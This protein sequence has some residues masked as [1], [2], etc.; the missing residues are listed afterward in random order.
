MK[1]T[2][3]VRSTLLGGVISLIVTIVTFIGHLL[4][5]LSFI[6][7]DIFDWMARV[8]PGPLIAHVIDAIVATINRF[9]LGPTASTAK[10][11]EQGIAVV[12]F[13]IFGLI[14]GLIIGLTS[15]RK[16]IRS[17]NLGLG[18]GIV[19]WLIAV[20]IDG[21][22][23]FPSD[24]P[25]LSILWLGVVLISAG[26]YLGKWIA[27]I[28]PVE[29]IKLSPFSPERRKFLL[30]TGATGVI[31]LFG[32]AAVVDFLR[33]PSGPLS[34]AGQSS[35]APTPEKLLPP[36]LPSSGP[37]PS[38]SAAVLAKRILAAPGTR[39][40]LTS[41]PDFYRI[42]INTEVPTTDINK[43][44]LD[45]KGLVDNPVSL[46]IDQIRNRPSI[47][48]AITLSCISN[49]VG[50]DLISTGVWT[51]VPLKS[52]L[53]ELGVKQGAK[54]IYMT[55]FDG[56]YETLSLQEAMDERV[57]LVYDMNGEPL[58]ANHGFPLRIYIPNHYGMKQPKWISSLEL[59]DT[60]QSGYWV[61]RGW[62]KQATALTTSVIDT[63][64][65]AQDSQ[66]QTVP[67][68]GIAWAGDRG[69]QKVEVQVDNGSWV[70][71]QL[72][73]PPLSQLTWVQ[74]RYNFPYKVGYH[75]FAVRATD[76]T[77]AVQTQRVTDTFPAGATGY[78][79]V[80]INL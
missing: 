59:T 6:P 52:I 5:G 45:I 24:G 22:L 39:P 65:A 16:P 70:E 44:K 32:I 31:T 13:I 56:F 3:I 58:P 29:V 43:W 20:I 15:W 51:G 60:D 78:D 8:L 40:E 36:M 50:G 69:I 18:A 61:D 7:F 64:N 54:Y 23:D 33:Q 73:T 76:G 19:L 12:Q 25:L 66:A 53:N 68:G 80:I 38:P 9:N 37:S 27:A 42:D 14:I 2:F 63:K 26:W 35:A 10:M 4:A 21:Y 30:W 79:S 67:I 75:Q 48:Q 17:S 72:R 47:S 49:P 34:A 11:V 41:T 55:S 71:A 28:Q 46:A 74:W 57:M 62:S 77:G 1:R